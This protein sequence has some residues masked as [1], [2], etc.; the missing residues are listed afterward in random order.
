M[1]KLFVLCASLALAS[2]AASAGEWHGHL[3][4]SMCAAKMK[5]KAVS[6]KAKCVLNCA[7]SGFGVVTSDGKFVKFD[8]MGNAKA[9]EALKSTTREADLMVKVKGTIEGDVISVESVMIH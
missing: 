5:D 8:E 4:D 9:L 2:L 3:M 7:K 6:H 1:R